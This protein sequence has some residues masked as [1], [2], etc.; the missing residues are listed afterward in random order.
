MAPISALNAT[1]SYTSDTPSVC[2]VDTSTGA[3]TIVG[4]GTCTVTVTA[5][6]TDDYEGAAA[7]ASVSV[8]AAG[9]LALSVDPI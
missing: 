8:S 9:T 5:S 7:Q 6:E 2:T 4:N 1:I 3:L